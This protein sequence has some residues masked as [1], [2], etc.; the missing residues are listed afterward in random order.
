MQKIHFRTITPIFNFSFENEEYIYNK[1]GSFHGIDYTV[2]IKKYGYGETEYNN[3]LGGLA[4]NFTYEALTSIHMQQGYGATDYF[5]TCDLFYESTPE[6]ISY[7]NT[8]ETNTIANALVTALNIVSTKG[9]NSSKTYILRYPYSPLHY[10]NKNNKS[11]VQIYGNC[12]TNEP[13]SHPYF[14][15]TLALQKST[16]KKQ[17]SK[18]INSII[19]F[20]LM[21]IPE[22][23]F[24]RILT[25]AQ[26]YFK[27]AFTVERKEY[28]YL[29]LMIFCD[30]LFKNIGE[31]S[32]NASSKIAK[33]L[34][35]DGT[36]KNIINKEFFDNNDSFYKIRNYI[37]H[38]VPLGKDILLNEK[39]LEL[40]KYTRL[41]LIKTITDIYPQIDQ[42]NYFSDLKRFINEDYIN[43]V[44]KN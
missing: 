33:L 30:T 7:Q 28:A 44:K 16:L 25:I 22:T 34:A 23:Q 37:A 11:S 17:D 43:K 21:D 10:T 13:L 27:F 38:G 42:E 1:E 3:I 35:N 18:L 5:I 2:T 12:V 14:L 40:F 4:D 31:N 6:T 32:S 20:Y 19:D 24:T 39:L 15:N 26:D 29:Y 41:L 9:I 8:K 36:N